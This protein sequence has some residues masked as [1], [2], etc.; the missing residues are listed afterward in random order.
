PDGAVKPACR[1]SKSHGTAATEGDGGAGGDTAGGA[2]RTGSGGGAATTGGPG[3]G[4]GRS[5]GPITV[6]TGVSSSG[7]AE[8]APW[9]FNTI[10][11]DS[12]YGASS[13]RRVTSSWLSCASGANRSSSGAAPAISSAGFWPSAAG[14]P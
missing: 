9:R 5:F 13:E 6:T 4:A 10:G 14:T 7:G 11:S 1:R 2:G 3:G 12:M 8:V